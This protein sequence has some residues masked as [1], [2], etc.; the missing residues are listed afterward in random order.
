MGTGKDEVLIEFLSL[1]NA[2]KVTAIDPE[3]GA[4]VSIVGDPKQ[5]RNA[6]AA[7]AAQKLRYVLLKKDAGPSQPPGGGILV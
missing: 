7:L 2:L 3:T 4:E 6:L 5:S 1:G